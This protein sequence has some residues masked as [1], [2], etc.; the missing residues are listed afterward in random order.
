MDV[1]ALL[2]E[3]LTSVK[4]GHIPDASFL[5]ALVSKVDAFMLLV[6]DQQAT[7]LQCIASPCLCFSLKPE[8]SV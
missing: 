7:K 6:H 1:L 5:K 3:G 2:Q 8:T 4:S